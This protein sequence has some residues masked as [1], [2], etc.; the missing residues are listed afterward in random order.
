M[1]A[2]AALGGI[3]TVVGVYV[4]WVEASRICFWDEGKDAKATNGTIE[5]DDIDEAVSLSCT[6]VPSWYI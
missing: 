3:V 6:V 4:T 2:A 5:E 1:G